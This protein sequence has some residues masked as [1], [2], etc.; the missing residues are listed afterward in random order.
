MRYG[1]SI[2]TDNLVLHLDA[3][4]LN[5]YSGSG[6]TWADLS[7]NKNHFT[8][9]N[10]PTFVGNYNG[11]LQFDGVNDY[12]RSRNNTIVNSIA[13]NG[14]VE[15][16]CR[17]YNGSFTGTTSAYSRLIS[18]ANDTG[19]GSD[20]TST[21]GTN[22]DYINFFCI[23]QNNGTQYYNL[24]Y[25]NPSVSP[26]GLT[27]NINTNLYVQLI[28]SWSTNGSNMTFNHYINA[29]NVTSQTYTKTAYSSANN[30]T[31]AMN[32]NGSVSSTLENST[33]AYSI[34]RLYNR[35]L[36]ATEILQNYNATKGRFKLQ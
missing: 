29:F 8:L 4:D 5:S 23:A 7:G 1:P 33:T 26:F 18:I 10:G 20:T 2:I 16:W 12:A 11:E 13:A 15:I 35:A 36:S 31:L 25:V 17:S 28:M 3:A 22:N 24:Y 9:Y 27:T 14:T 21:Q 34:V 30:I 19:T 32:S 6:T